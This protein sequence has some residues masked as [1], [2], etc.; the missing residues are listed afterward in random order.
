PS[1]AGDPPRPGTKTVL[2]GFMG[3]GKSTAV[4]SL[5]GTLGVRAID[6]DDVIEERLGRSVSELF[7]SEGETMFRAAEERVTLELLCA[8]G[9]A[10]IA[11]GGGAVMHEA[12]R[13]EL[14]RH[15]VIWLD[16]TP[17]LAWERCRGGRRP[18]AT[19]AGAFAALHAQRE[20]TYAELADIEVPGAHSHDIA[21]V[22]AAARELPAGT[23]LIWATSDSGDYP[24]YIGPGLL[25]RGF[26]PATVDG[27]RFMVT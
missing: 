7:A 21:G 4:R 3:A 11:L 19:D 12:V 14:A 24:A 1:Q 23:R 26:W 2:I 25:R 18:L 13:R 8:P 16:V 27:R 17:E 15:R 20:S 6:V 5:A 10:V 9:E 22:V